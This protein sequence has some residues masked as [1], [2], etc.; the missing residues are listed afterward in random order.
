MGFVHSYTLSITFCVPVYWIIFTIPS[1]D[2]NNPYSNI[3]LVQY[4]KKRAASSCYYYCYYYKSLPITTNVVSSN[5][6]HARC[7]RYNIIRSSL[8][9]GR[10]VVFS[11]FST[12]KTDRDDITEILLKVALNTIDLTPLLLH[13]LS[14]NRKQCQ[15]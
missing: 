1:L 5:S 14:Y 11:G 13:L 2:I 15:L 6:A 9:C 12:N 4:L 10:S 8:T 7:T 3:Q